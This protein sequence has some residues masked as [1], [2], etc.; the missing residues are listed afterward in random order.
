MPTP[1]YR[2]GGKRSRIARP[3]VEPAAIPLPSN[4][5]YLTTVPRIGAVGSNA[6]T[7]SLPLMMGTVVF[8]AHRV[9][10]SGNSRQRSQFAYV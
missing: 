5:W 4:D 8:S 9:R 3:S 10:V 7:A 6:S 1:W 2:L